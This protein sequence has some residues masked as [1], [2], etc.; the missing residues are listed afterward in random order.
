MKNQILLFIFCCLPFFSFGQNLNGVYEKEN[1][2]KTAIFLP[3]LEIGYM[4]EQTRFLGGGLLMK[5]SIE[6]RT[7]KNIFFKLN[8]DAANTRYNL[9]AIPDET[10]IIEGTT[11]MEDLLLGVGYRLGNDKVQW[12]F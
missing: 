8:F 2:S 3:A 6:Y 10:N 4:N 12:F 1:I 11:S 9:D 7:K 5:T